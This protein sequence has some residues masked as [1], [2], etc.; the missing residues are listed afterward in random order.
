MNIMILSAGTR[1]SIV[2]YF[3]RALG[4]S[5]R[6]IATDMSP[7][8]SALYEADGYYIVP[9]VGEP[10]YMDRICDICR[11]EAVNPYLSWQAILL[12]RADRV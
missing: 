5:G 7:L 10:G 4:G 1:N 3:R 8:A 2:R 9:P 12:R 6:V 11:K